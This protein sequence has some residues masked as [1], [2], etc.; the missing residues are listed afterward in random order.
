MMRAISAT[1][2]AIIAMT[3]ALGGCAGRPS[4]LPNSD[5]SLRRTSAQFA[6][7]AAKRHPFKADAPSGGQAP[8]TAQYDLT[9]AT[10]QLLN[11][12]DED[13]DNIEVWVNRNYVCFIPVLEKGKARVKTLNFQMLYDDSGN[14]FWTDNGKNP[15]QTVE[16]YRNGKMYT[17]PTN[18]GD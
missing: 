10:L 3:A 4:L 6:A 13:W 11:V 8:V 2:L 9:F 5:P 1:T 15:I 12:G 17:V 7:D 16:I 18:M 14:Y